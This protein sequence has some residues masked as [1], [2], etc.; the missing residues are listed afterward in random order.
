MIEPDRSTAERLRRLL[1]KPELGRLLDA[2][3]R[4]F[5]RGVEG[6][7]LTLP[8]ASEAERR[9][10]A[11]LLGRPPG[12]GR[13]LSL[14]LGALEAALRRAGLVDSL[15]QA[16]ECLRG[17]L[18]DLPAERQEET[19]AW[20]AI[21]D[22][23]HLA[24]AEHCEWLASL[25]AG[26]LLKRLAKRD[27]VVAG[28]L[29]DDALRLLAHLPGHG[30]TLST[31]AATVLGDA[32][33]L[34][35][36]R[37][38]ATLVTNALGHGEDEE[39]TRALWARHGILVGGAITSTVLLLNL[40]AGGDSLTAR[41]LREARGQPLWITLRQLVGDPVDWSAMAGRTLHLCENPAVVAEAAD[42][43]G[44]RC[45]PLVCTNGQPTAAVLYLIDQL[46]RAGARLAYHGDFDWAGL[47][48]ANS[49]FRRFPVVP[50]RFG[51]ADYRRAVA[52]GVGKRLKREKVEADW[53]AGL[54]S[55]MAESA[56]VVEEEAAL[57]GL[58]EDL[59]SS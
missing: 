51:E 27:P 7:T 16:V 46:H 36:G 41:T 22:D 10:V 21:F 15:R 56:M 12:R 57:A 19:S 54:A 24:A 45:A 47:R 20:S 31:L 18:R 9:A 43:L 23:A 37:P 58:L 29:L 8:E 26:G 44:E 38:V 13:N 28:R 32:H 3:Q 53:D 48:I 30:Q 39:Q 6:D 17:P 34:D 55:A 35:P 52:D 40:P 49:L 14:R 11:A 2:L 50:W 5:E 4:R 25:R 1:G 59:A 42:R 33:A